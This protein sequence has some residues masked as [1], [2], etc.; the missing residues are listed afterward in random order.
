MASRTARKDF[1]I[2]ATMKQN[3]VFRETVTVNL[4]EG[5][6]LVPCSKI[7]KVAQGFEGDVRI[8]KG[9][10]AV[11]AKDIFELPT[12][13]ATYGTTLVLEATGEGADEVI[14]QLVRLFE[15]NFEAEES[16]DS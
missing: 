13:V 2:A 3:S 14:E 10:L 8:L 5:L 6:H 7:V 4:D 16:S 15:S 1:I 9:D 12:L 11:D